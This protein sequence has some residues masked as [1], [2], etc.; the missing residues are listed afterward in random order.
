M[1]IWIDAQL[2]PAIAAWIAQNLSVEAV[3]LRDIGLRDAE[4]EQIFFAARQAN[5]VV[6]TKDSDFLD[7]LEKHGP[8]PQILWLTCGNS[9]NSRLKEILT[10]TLQ[11][12]IELFQ[13]GERLIELGDA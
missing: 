11:N 3:A 8:P 1:T 4:D 12:A 6:L 10:A 7:L 9:S 2:P 5:A 13:S